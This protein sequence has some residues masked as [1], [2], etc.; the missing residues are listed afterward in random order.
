MRIFIKSIIS[1]TGALLHCCETFPFSFKLMLSCFDTI[2]F[3]FKLMLSYFDTSPFFLNWY[4]L[5][6]TLSHFLL[7][8]FYLI[9][10][11]SYFLL[12]S[13]QSYFDTIPFSVK[14]M[15]SCFDIRIQLT[16][17]NVWF[18]TRSKNSMC[19]SLRLNFRPSFLKHVN[20]WYFLSMR[21]LTLCWWLCW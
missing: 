13:C 5:I 4:Y 10:T 18:S 15:Q 3:S 14:L 12:N 6:L 7:K 9:L 1:V 2:P 11:L 19:C 16:E 17:T 8:S 20:G 21:W